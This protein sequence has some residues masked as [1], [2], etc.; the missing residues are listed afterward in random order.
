MKPCKYCGLDK[1]DPRESTRYDVLNPLYS[2]EMDMSVVGPYCSD[3]FPA[4]VTG[5][6]L[7]EQ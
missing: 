7:A 6:A 3:C 4:T 2:P 5:Q 1:V